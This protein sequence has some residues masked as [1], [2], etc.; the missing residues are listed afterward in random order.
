MKARYPLPPFNAETALLKVQA[1]EDGWNTKDAH[2]VSLAYTIDSEWRNRSEFIN[3]REN[4]EKFL[5]DKWQKELDYKLKKTLWC[6]TDNHIAVTFFY[7]WHDSE[8]NWFRSYGNEMWQFDEHGFM[9]K[10]I[11]SIND[12]PISESDRQLTD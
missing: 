1:A 4:I 5:E 7:E 3:G 10:R 11:A 8:G 12:V 2:K 9:K 6:Y